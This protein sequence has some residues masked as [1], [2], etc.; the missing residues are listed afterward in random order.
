MNIEVQSLGDENP[1]DFLAR[2][3]NGIKDQRRYVHLIMAAA[4]LAPSRE[5]KALLEMVAKAV[6]GDENTSDDCMALFKLYGEISGK[7][8]AI[9]NDVYARAEHLAGEGK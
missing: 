5:A 9:A 8:D 7:A 2:C 6:G 4:N 3:A 1:V